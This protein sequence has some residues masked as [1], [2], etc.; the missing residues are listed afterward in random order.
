MTE[1]FLNMN[2]G[3]PGG[4]EMRGVRM[5]ESMRSSA[6]IQPRSIPVK[7]NELLNRPNT[8]MTAQPIIEERGLR[9]LREPELI[10][11]S[12]NFADTFLGDLIERDDPTTRPFANSGG[13]M[14]II[15]GLTIMRHETD[16]EAR[17]FQAV[18]ATASV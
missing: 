5:A 15:A 2:C 9:G 17:H 1:K 7:S 14:K 18:G 12:E 11:E 4:H 13:E 6:D 16:R 10:F 3:N 8:E